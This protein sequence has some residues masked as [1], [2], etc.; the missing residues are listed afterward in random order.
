MIENEL[1]VILFENGRR[2]KRERTE[3]KEKKNGR[4]GGGRDAY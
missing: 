1:L 3:N 2:K 4:D